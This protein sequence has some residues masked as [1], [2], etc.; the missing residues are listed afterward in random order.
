MSDLTI[1]NGKSEN[2]LIEKWNNYLLPQVFVNSI[3]LICLDYVLY[4]FILKLTKTIYRCSVLASAQILYNLCFIIG[5]GLERFMKGGYYY[6]GI[7]SIIALINSFFINSSE[8][9]L[10]I[11]EMREIRFDENK[12]KDK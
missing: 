9:S 11:S 12:N 5:I 7:F 10:N 3:S 4:F 1:Y 6:A 2:Q 8:D